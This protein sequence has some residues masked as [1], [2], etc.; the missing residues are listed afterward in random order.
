MAFFDSSE[1]YFAI[2]DTG[3]TLRDVSP[4]IVA[5]DGLPGPRDLGDATT[6]NDTGHKWHPSLENVTITLEL[7]WS[8]DSNVGSD[9]VFGPLRTHTAA[10]D[11][12]YGP[13][14]STGGDIKYSGTCWLRN[15]TVQTRVGSL[16]LCRV[17]LA[18]EGTVTR[19]TF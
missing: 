15:Y 7:L 12:E 11:F 16:V 10:V 18:V 3:A 8:P 13:Q 14:G 4:Y 1:S 5:I 9:T 2:D 19:G 6:I 17:E